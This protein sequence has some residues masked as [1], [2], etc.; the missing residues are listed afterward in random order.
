MKTK[1]IIPATIMVITGIG[2]INTRAD[3]D[4]TDWGTQSTNNYNLS[5][6]KDDT[7]SLLSDG[8]CATR[9]D[10][11]TTVWRMDDGSCYYI[12]SCET[13]PSGYEK[14][15]EDTGWKYSDYC[16]NEERGEELYFLSVVRYKCVPQCTNCDSTSWS[17]LRTGYQSR[18][19]R[20]CDDGTCKSQTQYRCAAGY[21]GTS[22]NGTSGCTQC[23]AW[24]GVY[25]T[26]AKTTTLRG[27]SDAGATQI[28]ECYVSAGTH[29]DRTGTFKISSTCQYK[30]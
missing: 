20:W 6:C 28:T 2:I 13:C 24:S 22:S 27:T 17:A 18:I 16:W 29:Y 21:Y 7:L 26:P 4:C 1:L 14:E 15:Y 3:A 11:L 30:K 5:S 9:D 10:T 8:H 25:T 23:P 19:F 12:P